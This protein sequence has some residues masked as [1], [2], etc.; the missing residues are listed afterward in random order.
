MDATDSVSSKEDNNT[1][2]VTD[3][4]LNL[5][6]N[7]GSGNVKNT[8]Q[9]LEEGTVTDP[10]KSKLE[11]EEEEEIAFHTFE[12]FQFKR[13]LSSGPEYKRAVLEGI[14]AEK[15]TIIILEKKPFAENSL[16]E[17]LSENSKL[18]R[19][20]QNDIY[21]NYDCLPIEKESSKSKLD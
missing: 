7:G 19:L 16:Q 21:G 4:V 9:N 8:S 17:L 3:K 5:S 18:T 20:V 13:I 1:L 12:G 10:K 2:V 6:S 15:P 11:S 14:Y